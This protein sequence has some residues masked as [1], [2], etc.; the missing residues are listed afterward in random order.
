MKKAANILGLFLLSVPG[1]ASAA[2]TI[3]L[4]KN[5]T[6]VQTFA[7]DLIYNTFLPILGVLALGSLIWGGVN[8]M[9]AGGDDAK[10]TKGRTIITYSIVGILLIIF[11]YGII[12]W[13]SSIIK[14]NI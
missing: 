8:I 6:D 13:L 9:M 14:A 4:K 3:V 12:N 5:T 11:A 1:L 10:V 2:E 7:L